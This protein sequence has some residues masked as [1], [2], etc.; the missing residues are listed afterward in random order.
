MEEISSPAKRRRNREKLLRDALEEEAAWFMETNSL[1][2][3]YEE[4]VRPAVCL[5]V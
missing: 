1:S 2:L 4:A 3:V 5:L